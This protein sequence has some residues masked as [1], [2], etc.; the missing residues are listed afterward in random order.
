MLGGPRPHDCPC[1]VTNGRF[2]TEQAKGKKRGIRFVTM[3]LSPALTSVLLALRVKRASYPNYVRVGGP[4][5]LINSNPE[6]VRGTA[7]SKKGLLQTVG[8]PLEL[9]PFLLTPSLIRT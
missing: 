4:Y 6:G 9:H 7:P 8:L 3:L 1:F 2:V 5:A